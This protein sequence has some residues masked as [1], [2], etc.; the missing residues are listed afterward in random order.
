MNVTNRLAN[1]I[2]QQHIS[3]ERV[4]KD[5]GVGIEKLIPDTGAVLDATEFLEVCVYLGIR[6]EDMDVKE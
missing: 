3:P 6:P 1:Y 4:S 2:R 5:T